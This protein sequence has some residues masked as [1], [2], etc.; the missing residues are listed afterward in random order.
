MAEEIERV[1]GLI[2]ALAGEALISVDTY[3]PQVAAA[4][5]KAGAAIVND[6][7]GL[8][9]PQRR[10]C[11]RRRGRVGPDAHGGGAQG[12]LLDPATY[13]DVVDEVVAFLRARMDGVRGRY[14]R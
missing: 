7:S 14:G 6:V 4:A 10:R 5:I 12:T 1:C 9:D 2:A 8:R 11:A 3:K 13:E